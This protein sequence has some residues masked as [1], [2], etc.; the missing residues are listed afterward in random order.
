MIVDSACGQ[1]L[2]PLSTVRFDAADVDRKDA[3]EVRESRFLDLHRNDR[4]ACCPNPGYA[5][6]SQG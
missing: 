1:A 2:M 3:I 4:A 6:R 5:F